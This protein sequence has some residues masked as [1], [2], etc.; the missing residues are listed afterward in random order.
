MHKYRLFFY[1]GL[2][3]LSFFVFGVFVLIVCGLTIVSS[4]LIVSLFVVWVVGGFL[5]GKIFFCQKP[6]LPA[7]SIHSHKL[8]NQSILIHT[9]DFGNTDNVFCIHSSNGLSV[10]KN[11]G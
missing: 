9:F 5:L 11:S 8:P 7:H 3:R 1:Y 4:L 2:R 6:S 10:N